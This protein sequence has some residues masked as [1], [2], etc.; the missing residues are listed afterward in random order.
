[1]LQQ[2]DCKKPVLLKESCLPLFADSF[3]LAEDLV[4]V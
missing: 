4:N 1:M 2:I 3:H